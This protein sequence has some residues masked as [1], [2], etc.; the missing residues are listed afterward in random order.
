MNPFDG[1]LNFLYW[2]GVMLNVNGSVDKV[3]V[4]EV[5]EV[6]GVFGF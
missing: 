2:Q 1:D 3:G 4:C 6:F 5:R